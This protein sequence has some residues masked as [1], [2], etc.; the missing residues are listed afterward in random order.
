MSPVHARGRR[1]GRA[2]RSVAVTAT[3]A[4]ALSVLAAC[5]GT[6][7]T[8]AA[9]GSAAGSTDKPCGDKTEAFNIGVANGYTGNTWRTQMLDNLDKVG[10]DLKSEGAIGDLEIV[11]SPANAST[12]LTQIQNFINRKMDAILIAPVDAASAKTAVTRIKAAGITPY[13]VTDPA[14]T[15]DA[16][17]VVGGD[18]TWWA[19]QAEWFVAK[20]GGKGKI[21]MLTGLAGNPSDTVRTESVKKI[22]EEYPDI[23]VVASVPGDWDPG[24]ARAAME[25]VLATNPQIDG[26]LQQDIMAPGVIQAFKAA[27]RPLPKV[28]TGDYT[29]TFLKQWKELPELE[30]MGVPYTPTVASDALKI[31]SRLCAGEKLKSGVLQNNEVDPSIK[32]SALLMPPAL[33]ITRDGERGEWTPENMEVITLDEALKRVEGKPETFAVEAPITDEEIDA[34]FQ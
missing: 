25:P 32:E 2:R 3:A 34:L 24:K 4:A 26:V 16:M 14:P 7:N 18:D 8:S 28:M 31:I 22:L 19:T 27:G 11:S 30:T 33:A 12:Q 6:S 23:E 5:G 1:F 9:G 29:H 21:V 15:P 10:A 20:M 17:N 13:I